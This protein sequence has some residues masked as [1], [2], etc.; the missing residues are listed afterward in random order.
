MTINSTITL[1]LHVV[2]DSLHPQV[3]LGLIDAAYLDR[4]Q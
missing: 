3:P 1:V 4:V 2:L